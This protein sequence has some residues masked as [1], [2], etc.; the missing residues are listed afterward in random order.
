MIKKI[1]KFLEPL[2]AKSARVLRGTKSGW[3]IDGMPYYPGVDSF[4]S[5]HVDAL[6]KDSAYEAEEIS[7][8]WVEIDS[9]SGSIWL[10]AN[11]SERPVRHLAL[12]RIN[13]PAPIRRCY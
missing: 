4:V 2:P 3:H 11:T 5:E 10:Q 13:Q 12:V 8:V 1:K 7:E 6:I 9:W